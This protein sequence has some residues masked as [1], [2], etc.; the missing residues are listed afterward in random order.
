MVFNL[1]FA[2]N[3]TFSCFISFFLIIELYLLVPAA[4]AL[5]SNCTA[6]LAIPIGIPT[7]EAIEKN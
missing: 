6:E 2:N 3:I 5:I 4:R 1:V 7:N